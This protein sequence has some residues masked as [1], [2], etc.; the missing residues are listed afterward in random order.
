M[1]GG[2]Y[3]IWVDVTSCI[4]QGKKS[5]G[6]KETGEYKIKV[7]SSPQNS[8]L[9]ADVIITKRLID[10]EWVFKYSVDGIIIKEARFEDNNGKPGNIIGEPIL[11]IQKKEEIFV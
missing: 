2:N 3:P 10:G 11:K 6:I 8:H 9:L 1:R 7:G 4:Y 5:Y